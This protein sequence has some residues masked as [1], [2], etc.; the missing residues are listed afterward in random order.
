MSLRGALG[1]GAAW[2][3]G[4]LASVLF[5]N[6]H[7][8]HGP[9]DA[10]GVHVAHIGVIAGI[11]IT[12]A[13]LTVGIVGICFYDWKRRKRADKAIGMHEPFGTGSNNS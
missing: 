6:G 9:R 5:F 13:V 2:L 12:I 7:G 8:A 3:T 10:L 11:T 1:A 4:P